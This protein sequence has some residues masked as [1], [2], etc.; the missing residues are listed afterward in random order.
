MN[1]KF[2][3]VILAML[4]VFTCITI[5]ITGCASSGAKTDSFTPIKWDPTVKMGTLENGVSYYIK[6]NAIP[7]NRISLRLVIQAGS[8]MEEDDEKGVAHLIEHMAFNGT[9]RFEK[10]AI[11]DYFEKI[12]MNF[13]SDLNAETDFENTI[14]KLEIP[15]DD[16]EIIE[17]AMQIM[18]DW[19]CAIAFDPEEI[20]KERGVVV[21]DWRLRQ[22]LSGR[23]TNKYLE[24]LAKD[25][26]FKERLPIGDMDVVR[27]I[28]REKI[29]EFY[30]KWYR[31]ELISVVVAGDIDPSVMEK[32][33]KKNM[34]TIPASETRITKPVYDIPLPEEK[35]IS[36]MKDP[37]QTVT[38][39]FFFEPV[40]DWQPRKTV[41]DIQSL[42]VEQIATSVLNSRM[43]E[44]TATAD[45]PWLAAGCG[46]ISLTNMT[47]NNYIVV[48]PKSEQTELALKCF[49]DEI[50][51]FL[52]YGVTESELNRLVQGLKSQS[53]LTY[54]NKDKTENAT[55]A[56]GLIN[57]VKLGKVFI[58]PEDLKKAED[59]VLP[60][61]TV[62]MVNEEA[63]RLFGDRGKSMLVIAPQNEKLPAEKELMSIWK[64]YR[65]SE[66]TAYVDDVDDDSFM[67]KP[68]KK[69]KITSKKE[70][71]TLGTKEY[72]LE[73]GI[74][75]ITKKT[76]FEKN[77][78]YLQ[79]LSEGGKFNI[80]DEDLP[81][82]DVSLNYILYS[83][84]KTIPYNQFVKKLQTKQISLSIGIGD[85]FEYLNG[86]CNVKDLEAY[87]QVLN[88]LFDQAQFTD[89]S[90]NTIK[91]IYKNSAETYG[92]KPEDH[93]NR[94]INEIYYGKDDLLHA[95]FDMNTYNNLNQESAERVFRQRF[96]NPADFTFIFAGDFDETELIDN[97]CYYLGALKT[98][99]NFEKRTYKYWDFP[100]GKP[101]KTVNKGIGDLGR[102]YMGFGGTLPP[103]SDIEA[104]YK[105]R[106][107]MGLLQDVLDIRLREV[108][109]EDKSGVYGIST[110]G[111]IDGTPERYYRVSV[112][113]GCEPERQQELCDEVLNQMKNLQNEPV[114]KIYIDKLKETY[115]RNREVNLW[116][117]YWWMTRIQNE[118][119]LENEPEWVTKDLNKLQS[120]ITAENI[121]NAAKKYL[122]TDNYVSVF[123]KPENK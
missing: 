52:I 95:P 34:S 103:E 120:W 46:D 17:T 93:F 113:F 36:V 4:I 105:E 29:I 83:G 40:P 99:D 71:K 51:K 118:L 60:S 12:G 106:Y 59:K 63:R 5:S 121:Q 111:Y 55:I 56:N 80:A 85:V 94:A 39:V 66:I 104:A 38:Q 6:K 8:V 109:R 65:N 2:K 7:A 115:K 14:Y 86:S 114:D 49:F 37:E 73:N 68:S 91:Q 47:L 74:R 11:V 96:D 25:S 89:D 69:A 122:N 48:F 43:N 3:K 24:V 123:L 50:D 42:Y 77:L 64:D 23:V 62:E 81:S 15:A 54:Q 58:S 31:P 75:I 98:N 67:A 72:V 82:V 27:N 61:I 9:E 28:S 107:I 20:E 70:N 22:N 119:V 13:G 76:D 30:K 88:L 87:L 35:T 100:E 33:I 26:R 116:E 41:E 16:P 112:N 110:D 84:F 97:C 117:N 53:E 45:S 10:S 57:Y 18:H 92:S 44:I 101:H 1:L 19:S 102:V 79:V 32:S 90:W 108:I 21:E 78:V